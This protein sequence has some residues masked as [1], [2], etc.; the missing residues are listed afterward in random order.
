MAGLQGAAGAVRVRSRVENW[1][2][3]SAASLVSAREQLVQAIR[4]AETATARE[5]LSDRDAEA[6]A[7]DLATR[8]EKKLAWRADSEA[9]MAAL[10][11]ERTT[12]SS[13]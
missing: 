1:L 7:A 4:T 3:D 12:R 2:M 5:R 11:K 13:S 6:L 9:R 10:R 8:L